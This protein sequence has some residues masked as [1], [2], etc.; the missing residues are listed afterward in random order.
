MTRRFLVAVAAA[1]VLALMW[2]VPAWAHVTVHPD[3]AVKGSYTEL[4]FRVPNEETNADTT[5]VDV[6]FP[7]D[8]PI[9]NV[10]VKP[11]PGWTY[12]VKMTRL[13]KP[14]KTDDGEVSEVVSEIIWT[15]G[16][17]APGQF[18][19]FEVS[20]GPMPSDVDQIMFPTIQTYSD[21]HDVAW[22]EPPAARGAPEPDHPAP[23]LHLTKDAQASADAPASPANVPAKGQP[24]VTSGASKSD[25][26]SANTKA[27]IGIVLGAVGVAAA[28]GALGFEVRRARHRDT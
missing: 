6:K 9:A 15:G 26:D 11:K 21:N 20:A 13:A 1:S 28:L 7:T 17:V 2:A 8:H 12:T 23:L 16:K 24:N 19:D 3:T 27:L 25:V 10:S 14:L 18:D 5:Q 4:S 22:I